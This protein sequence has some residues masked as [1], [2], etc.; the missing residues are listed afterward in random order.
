MASTWV[1]SPSSSATL[2]LLADGRLP[3]G[4]HVHSGG[5]EAAVADGRVNDVADLGRYLLGRLTTTGRVEAA[6]AA[7]ALGHFRRSAAAAAA[8]GVDAVVDAVVVGS[9]GD[10]TAE[11]AAV[12]PYGAAVGADAAAGWARLDAEAVARA[13]SPALRAAG[14][15]QGRG[16][17]RAGRRIWPAPQ[18]DVLVAALPG[19]PMAPVALGAVGAAAGLVPADVTLA[20]AQS[21]ISGPAWAAVRLLGLDP[22]EVVRVLAELAGAVDAEAVAAAGWAEAGADWA[23]LPAGGAPLTDIAAEAHAHWEVRLFA[24]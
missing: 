22:F 15:A 20:A 14:R 13:P 7:A 9:V 21:S 4:G 23:D 1:T 17:I 10:A 2:L 24:S 12:V 6:L 18:L 8:D 5:V 11:V 3:A 16:L 19:P